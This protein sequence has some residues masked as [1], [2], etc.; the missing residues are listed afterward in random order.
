MA[1]G[2]AAGGCTMGTTLR[3]PRGGPAD[4]PATYEKRTS[5]CCARCRKRRTPPSVRFLGRRV[6]LGVVVVLAC[7][8][9]QRPTPWRVTRL[10]AVLGVSREDARSVAP[11]VA[12]RLRRTPFWRA[13]Q[14]C[15]ARP[16]DAGELPRAL[17]ERFGG[18]PLAQILAALRFL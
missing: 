13:S 1:A 10:H 6:Y 5:F 11:L 17:L 18:D 16:V 15:F 4:L 14:S 2:A 12:P 3:K 8:L 7:V 9:R